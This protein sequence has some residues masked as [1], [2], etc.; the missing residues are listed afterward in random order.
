MANLLPQSMDLL[1]AA[2]A[3]GAWMPWRG[4][5]GQIV[6]DGTFGG[7]TV[8][9]EIQGPSGSGVSLGAAGVFAAAG[10]AGFELAEGVNIRCSISGGS[11]TAVNA[12]VRWTGLG[13]L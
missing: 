2:S 9:L 5:R 8:T 4:G 7:A 6:V 1:S 13:A 3:T 11:G 10:V 12:R